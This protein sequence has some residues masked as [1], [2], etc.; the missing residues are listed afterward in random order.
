MAKIQNELETAS[1]SYREQT[2]EVIAASEGGVLPAEVFWAGLAVEDTLL[3]TQNVLA[4]KH[5]RFP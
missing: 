3:W 4:W 1:P 2:A 5:L